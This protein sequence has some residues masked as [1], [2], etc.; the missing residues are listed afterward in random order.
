MGDKNSYF[1]EKLRVPEGFT[2]K[3]ALSLGYAASPLPPR[4][5]R[6]EKRVEYIK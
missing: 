2:P 5:D 6:V 1:R 4:K 3:F